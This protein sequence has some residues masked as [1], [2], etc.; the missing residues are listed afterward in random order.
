MS[1]GG[2]LLRFAGA[3]TLLLVACQLVA[4]AGGLHLGRLLAL[5]MLLQLSG[6]LTGLL[7]GGLLGSDGETSSRDATDEPLDWFRCVSHA[8]TPADNPLLRVLPQKP[9]ARQPAPGLRLCG[10][11]QAVVGSGTQLTVVRATRRCAAHPTRQRWTEDLREQEVRGKSAVKSV[12]R[13]NG[14]RSVP[15]GGK[16][17]GCGSSLPAARAC[18]VAAAQPSTATG[19]GRRGPVADTPAQRPANVVSQRLLL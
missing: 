5:C 2:L 1:A 18:H 4:T 17:A 9:G 19:D 6:G 15:A 16:P 10:E 12:P 3:G 11:A 14:P 8:A 7:V 13:N